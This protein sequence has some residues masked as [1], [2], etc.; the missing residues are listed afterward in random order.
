MGRSLEGMVERKDQEEKYNSK[1]GKRRKRKQREREGERVEEE[2]RREKRSLQFT[3]LF[4]FFTLSDGSRE[5]IDEESLGIWAT[6]NGFL[7]KVD[8]DFAWN[9][10][11]VLHDFI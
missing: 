5:A 6:F 1:E 10:L 4:E 8:G 3:Y 2:K 7:K 9:D 11:T